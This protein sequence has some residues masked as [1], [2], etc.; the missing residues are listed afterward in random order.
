MVSAV[1]KNPL[2]VAQTHYYDV[3]LCKILIIFLHM[4]LIFLGDL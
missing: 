2:C 3:I 4:I 1:F